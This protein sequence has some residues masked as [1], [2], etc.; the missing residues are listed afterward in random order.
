MKTILMLTAFITYVIV[1][2]LTVLGHSNHMS[3]Y[4]AQEPAAIAED[5]EGGGGTAS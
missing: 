2:N 5:S 3:N 1:G 4:M